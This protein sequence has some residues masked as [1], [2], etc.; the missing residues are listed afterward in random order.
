MMK[1]Y[2]LKKCFCSM[3]CFKDFE[4]K[5]KTLLFVFNVKNNLILKMDLFFMINKSFVLLNVKKN[6]LKKIL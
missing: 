5:K 1:I 6:I 2:K 3:K 4:V